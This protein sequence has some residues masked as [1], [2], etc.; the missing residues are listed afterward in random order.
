MADEFAEMR[1]AITA[2][3]KDFSTKMD[4]FGKVIGEVKKPTE[5]VNKG[6]KEVFTG[7]VAGQLTVDALKGAFGAMVNTMKQSIDSYDKQFVATQSLRT[8]LGYTSQALLDQAS[9]LQKTTRFGDEETIA[10]QSRIAMFIKEEATIKRMTPAVMNFAAAKGISLTAAADAVTKSVAS[11]TNAL[12]RYGIQIEG[13]AG[14]SERAESAILA[15]NK[16]F[17]GQAEAMGKAGA[18]PLIALNNNMGDLQEL[19]GQAVTEG[20]NPFVNAINVHVLP[21]LNN[22]LTK[23]LSIG[24]ATQINQLTHQIDALEKKMSDA[25][26]GK[27]GYLEAA[28]AGNAGWTG[29]GAQLMATKGNQDILMSQLDELKKKKQALLDQ[30]AANTAAKTTAETAA[31]AEIERGKMLVRSIEI[32][33]H[34]LDTYK[35]TTDQI[36]TELNLALKDHSKTI[37]EVFAAKKAR[38]QG[39]SDEEEKF[40]RKQIAATKDQSE[41]TAA[42]N[43]IE[44]LRIGTKTKLIQLEG[45]HADAL[46]KSAKEQAKAIALLNKIREQQDE[47][48]ADDSTKA[49]S[50]SPIAQMR[51]QHSKA[52]T[53]LRKQQM[54]LES[55]DIADVDR[56]KAR[57]AMKTLIE[58]TGQNQRNEIR[59]IEIQSA[60][61]TGVQMAGALANTLD[62]LFQAGGGKSR[63]LFNMMK[64]ANIAQTVMNTSV[65]VMKSWA[66][67]GPIAGPIMAGIAIAQGIAQIAMISS[68]K[69][70]EPKAARGGRIVG[71]SHDNGGVS[72]EVEGDEHIIRK[73]SARMYGHR[74]L[75]AIN[76]GVVP[77]S[78]L[79]S[80][81]TGSTSYVQGR[82]AKGGAVAGA[83]ENTIVNYFDPSTFGRFLAS[84]QGKR[85]VVNRMSE[86]SFERRKAIRVKK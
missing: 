86:S 25:K 14:S 81:A 63:A 55:A 72:I 73:S 80:L 36:F 13:T 83:S 17:G 64:T 69:F 51:K 84:S 53:Q 5:E 31:A 42:Q 45:E 62:M 34:A 65:A 68:Q 18:G 50:K 10:A 21:A 47:A 61:N 6:F 3:L 76:R 24:N 54:D 33:Q 4:E 27:G 57:E 15:L 37:D 48:D 79:Q 30:D 74:T 28:W 70:P 75:D 85:A 40:L 43:K 49:G 67:L 11:E 7:F 56:V 59:N 82:A 26:K 71:P 38:I 46:E 52:M 19:L 41:K 32:G 78:A 20:I 35:A 8:A 44:L 58:T 60:L 9:A 39:Q 77:P 1:V 29:A 23:A 22:W 12:A 16:A 66:E 2:S